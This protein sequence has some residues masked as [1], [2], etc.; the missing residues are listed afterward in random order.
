MVAQ[1]RNYQEITMHIPHPSEDGV[2]LLL[3]CWSVLAST[4]S[5]PCVHLAGV[6]TVL[7]EYSALNGH[8]RE[9]SRSSRLPFM[10][11]F[12]PYW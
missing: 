1:Y 9:L 5:M 8:L 2:D 10:S 6:L 11:M 7:V 12:H 3:T 4:S